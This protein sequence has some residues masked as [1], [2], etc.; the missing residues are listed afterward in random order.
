MSPVVL[1][2]VEMSA[3]VKDT[4]VSPIVYEKLGCTQL[5]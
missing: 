5:C 3:I 4:E 1:K 2:D